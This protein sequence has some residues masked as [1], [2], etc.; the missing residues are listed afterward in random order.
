MADFLSKPILVGFLNGIA[1]SIFLGQ[2]GKLFGFPI[3]AGGIIPRLLEFVEKLPQTHA[4][5][6]A[7]GLGSCAVLVLSTRLLPRLPAP[8]IAMVAG[9]AAVALLN[10][11]RNGVTTLGLVPAGLP[12]LRWPTF[13]LE[14]LSS[15]VGSAAGLA[16]IMFTSGMLTARSF[17]SKAGDAIDTDREFAALGAA[18]LAAAISQGFAVTGADSRTA[19]G[20]AAGSRS[21]VT[22][23]VAAATIAI[24]LLF[25]TRPLQDVPLATLGAVLLSSAVSLFDV[26][27][28][29][30]IWQLD[31]REVLLS[32]ITTLSVVAVGAIN[33]ILIA[34]GLALTRFVRQV[35][36]P[37]D[38][39]LGAVDGLP[40]FHSIER[41]PGAKTLPGVVLYRF[42]SPV[43]FFNADYF[44]ARALAVAEAAGPALRWFVIDAIPISGLDV[45]GL[46][47]LR[48]LTETF[49]ARRITLILAGRRTEFLSLLREAGLYQPDHEDRLFPTLRQALKSYRREHGAAEP[50]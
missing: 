3:E 24:V 49:R 46:Y 9:A 1:I 39:V 8:L 23:L 36:R 31:R 21:Q 41:H 20:V 47:A 19:V 25:L 38:E 17:A 37:R 16:L 32:L 34:V 45:T 43:T 35:A 10:L 28:L 7:V 33:A 11:D 15:L 48:D 26:R 13:P 44:K 27:T 50:S 4:P 42:N 12:P 2:I 29:R 6:L 5:T 30:E 18:N 40:G 22:G 14:D